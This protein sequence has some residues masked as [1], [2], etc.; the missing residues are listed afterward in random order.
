MAE[1]SDEYIRRA[2]FIEQYKNG[3]VKR[4]NPFLKRIVKGLRDELLK[5]Q[6]VTSKARIKS[7]LDYIESMVD[8]ELSAFTG[9]LSE[10]LSLFADEESEFT[11]KALTGAVDTSA[12]IASSSQLMAAVNARPFNNRLLKDYLKDYSKEQARMVRNAVSEGF[13]NGKSTHEI[14]NDIV[15]TK[16]LGFKDG[17]LKMTR[18][19]AERMVRTSIAHTSAV[20]KSITLQENKDI[21]PFYEWSSVLDGRTSHICRAGDGTVYRVGKGPVAPHHF[22]CRSTEIPLF[23][24]EVN[25]KSLTKKKTDGKDQNYNDWLGKQSKSFQVEVLGVQKAELFRKGDI[26]MDQFTNDKGMELTLEQLKSKYPK[27]WNKTF[28]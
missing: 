14:V 17:V 9:D 2:H 27:Q 21:T 3:Q 1:L 13:Y 4:V 24:D 28:E 6:T 8:V 16:K 23:D 10:Q 15:G 18:T 11:A 25:T 20:A 22:N 7:K 12:T 26:R 19:S 5:T